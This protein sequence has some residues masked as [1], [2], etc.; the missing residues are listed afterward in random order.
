MLLPLL[1]EK[2]GRG[3]SRP[4][5]KT[6]GECDPFGIDIALPNIFENQIIPV[7]VHNLSKLFRPNTANIRVLAL[8]TNFIPK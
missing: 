2:S 6:S 3:G 4:N 8:G 7:G 5:V 1:S